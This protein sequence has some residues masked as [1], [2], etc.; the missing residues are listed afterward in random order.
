MPTVDPN[1]VNPWG[2]AFNP[3][4]PIWVADNGT[5]VSTVY[6]AQGAIIPLVVTVPPASG[7]TP[8]SAPTGLVFNPTSS[9]LGDKFIFSS[10]DGT[11]AGWNPNVDN[12]HA[13]IAVDRS[14]A[15]DGAGDVGANYKGLALVTTPAGKFIY[16]TSFRFGTVDVFDSHFNLVNSFTD[17]TIPAGFAPFGIHNIGGKLYVTFAKQGDGKADDDARPGNG[18]VEGGD[19]QASATFRDVGGLY[20]GRGLDGLCALYLLRHAAH[21]SLWDSPHLGC[22]EEPPSETCGRTRQD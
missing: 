12:S 9:F 17:P 14:T 3:T 2:L 22:D 4:G 11:I 20:T 10:E 13:V 18:F 19:N 7:G 6:T 15:T 16:A 1:L 21:F 8:P 5:G